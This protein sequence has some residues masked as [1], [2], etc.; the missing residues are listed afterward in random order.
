MRPVVKTKEHLK[1]EIEQLSLS[2]NN[3]KLEIDILKGKIKDSKVELRKHEKETVQAL[4]VLKRSQEEAHKSEIKALNEKAKTNKLVE[5]NGELEKEIAKN[6][7]SLSSIKGQITKEE[8]S[9][10]ATKESVRL[11]HEKLG[12]DTMDICSKLQILAGKLGK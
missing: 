10:A 4:D 6:K 3:H 8:N 1:K 7:T 12:T 2:V 5:E 11:E 9:L